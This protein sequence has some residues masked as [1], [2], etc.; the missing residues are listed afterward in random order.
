MG[1]TSN[2]LWP[3]PALPDPANV[4]ADIQALADSADTDVKSLEDR[5]A[6]LESSTRYGWTFIDSGTQT[7]EFDVDF[8]AAGKYPAGTFD[9]LRLHFQPYLVSGNSW[10]IAQT[11]GVI[12]STFYNRGWIGWEFDGGTR[13][14]FE[15]NT[16]D[17]WALGYI[18][19]QD[20]CNVETTI[21]RAN[22]ASKLPMRS[23][24]NRGGPSSFDLNREIMHCHG[25]VNTDTL[26]NSMRLF[27]T[28]TETLGTIHWHV[29]GFL[30][31]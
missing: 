15:S 1:N 2:Y 27:V 5:I 17:R 10:L 12:D 26:I 7:G 24:S 11:N 23:V 6:A 28:G 30:T 16:S 14:R 9:I 8:T 25:S 19:A 29:E 22:V 4:P 20:G 21:Y 3:Y 18:S 13:N 31:P